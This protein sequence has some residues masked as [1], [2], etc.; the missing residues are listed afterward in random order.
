MSTNRPMRR[1]PPVAFIL[2]AGL[3]TY[4]TLGALALVPDRGDDFQRLYASAKAWAHGGNPYAIMIADTPNL[5]HPLLLPLFW[6]FSVGSEHS[7][8]IAWSIASLLLLA[9]CV[10]IISRCARVVPID[11]VALILASTGA[12]LALVYGQVSF[13]LMAV[14]TAAWAADRRGHVSRA[15]AMLGILSVLKPFYGLFGVYLLWRREWR[16]V[17]LYAGTLVTGTLAG[18]AIVGTANFLEWLARL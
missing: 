7:E 15:G 16:A 10:P 17:G 6:V 4:G 8:F 12:F 9:A 2:L 5:N 11:L 14:F 3:A 13:V 1:L 18:W